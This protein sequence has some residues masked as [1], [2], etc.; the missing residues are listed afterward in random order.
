MTNFRA[1]INQSCQTT[2]TLFSC[3][4]DWISLAVQ[5][6]YKNIRRMKLVNFRQWPLSSY[7]LLF[8]TRRLRLARMLTAPLILRH[9]IKLKP[10]STN[11]YDDLPLSI[12]ILA[13]AVTSVN[14]EYQI[15]AVW[16]V[17]RWR[18]T[19]RDHVLIEYLK[20]I[21][22]N[23]WRNENTEIYIACIW[24]LTFSQR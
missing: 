12:I 10:T 22:L 9:K 21:G 20:F 11:D 19:D 17:Q 2:C 8:Q 5:K 18:F 14:G 15:P 3:R 6:I 4:S 13:T 1:V 23:L 16:A 24:T 7:G